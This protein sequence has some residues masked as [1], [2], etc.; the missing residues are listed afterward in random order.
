MRMRDA[1]RTR[2]R[3]RAASHAILA[4]VAIATTLTTSASPALA[5]DDAEDEIVLREAERIEQSMTRLAE[6]LQRSTVA[7]INYRMIERDGK[8]FEAA[9]GMGSGVIVSRDGRIF[10]NVHVIAEHSRLEVVLHDG[11][12]LPAT[13]YAEV[14]AYDFAL[15]LVKASDLPAAEWAKT[16]GIRSGQ[17]ALAAGNPRGLALDGDP[18]ITLGIVSG[19]NRLARGSY[20]Y[21]N[22]IQTDAEINPGNSGGPL[23]D[24]EGRIIG[25]NGKIATGGSDA[26][27]NI[28]VG[29][30]I[31]AQQIQS[32]LPS[33]YGGG[34]VAPGYSGIVVADYTHAEGGVLIT[35]VDGRSPAGKAGI[36][37]GDR[38]VGV[39]SQRVA[40]H[41]EWLN[42]IAMMPGGASI[43]ITF[44]RKDKNQV[45]RFQLERRGDGGSR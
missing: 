25:I 40:S 26:K 35:G 28:G 24:V 16:S 11:R 9:V 20:D 2:S 44:V 27:T 21:L 34:Q 6:K 43:S 29:F 31:P 13:S 42:A 38:I 1:L 10:T 45:K 4:I 12:V 41:T 36:R 22:A 37:A 32:F 3:R 18:V 5:R 19:T 39:N 15:I 30:T 17:L 14:A 33:M 23:F 7:I 8:T